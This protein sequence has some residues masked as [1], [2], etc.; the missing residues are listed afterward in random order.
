MPM[1]SLLAEDL[2]LG[3]KHPRSISVASVAAIDG[4]ENK[5]YELRTNVKGEVFSDSSVVARSVPLRFLDAP[6]DLRE[7]EA[8]HKALQEERVKIKAFGRELP[9]CLQLLDDAIEA[10]KGHLE[11]RLSCKLNAPLHTEGTSTRH[12][13]VCEYNSSVRKG[14]KEHPRINDINL[15]LKCSWACP[16]SSAPA[17]SGDQLRGTPCVPVHQTKSILN[18]AASGLSARDVEPF[19]GSRLF[20]GCG[21]FTDRS[22]LCRKGNQ[23][24]HQLD[25]NHRISAVN[26][27]SFQLMRNQTSCSGMRYDTT[28]RQYPGDVMNADMNLTEIVGKI[29][30]PMDASGTADRDRKRHCGRPI[31]TGMSSMPFS[32]AS[33][34]INSAGYI[35]SSIAAA[36]LCPQDY[37]IGTISEELGN[38]SCPSSSNTTTLQPGGAM[39]RKPRRCWSPELHQRFLNALQNLGGCQVATPKQIRELMNVEGLTNDEVK[40]HLQKFRLHMKRPNGVVQHAIQSTSPQRTGH[41][42]VVFGHIWVPSEYGEHHHEQQAAKDDCIITS[43]EFLE[44]ECHNHEGEQQSNDISRSHINSEVGCHLSDLGSCNNQLDMHPTMRKVFHQKSQYVCCNAK[45]GISD[46]SNQYVHAEKHKDECACELLN[47]VQKDRVSLEDRDK[48][49]DYRQIQDIR[50]NPGDA[51]SEALLVPLVSGE[52]DK[53][54]LHIHEASGSYSMSLCGHRHANQS[55]GYQEAASSR[56]DTIIVKDT[57]LIIGRRLPAEKDTDL[58]PCV[59][60]E[61]AL[62]NINQGMKYNDTSEDSTDAPSNLHSSRA[63]SK[64]AQ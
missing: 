13:L 35:S 27:S 39:V 53:G 17:E 9:F 48:D 40:S 58:Q 57:D 4:K 45:E 18:V 34:N 33:A 47:Y 42:L 30:Q 60:S 46:C 36:S 1:P 12:G 14:V 6:S 41:H 16:N 25:S 8:Y 64:F 62:L 56:S 10:S 38:A 19:S 50:S 15:D 28:G 63:E 61:K 52:A 3:Y 54:I 55:F 59:Q 43:N 31:Q 32:A 29:L 37:H 44:S 5:A 26:S 49:H 2:C 23:T 51:V 11:D 20:D 21:A 24:G 22:F 7:L